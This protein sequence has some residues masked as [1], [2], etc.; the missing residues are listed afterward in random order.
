M[1]SNGS[2][3]VKIPNKSKINASMASMA[4]P[5]FVFTIVGNDSCLVSTPNLCHE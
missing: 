4:R 2:A 5:M 3:D 1:P